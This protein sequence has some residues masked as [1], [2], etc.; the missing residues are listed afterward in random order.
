MPDAR[1]T[2]PVVHSPPLPPLL[3]WAGGKRQLLPRILPLLPA[4]FNRYFEP[5]VGGG[6]LFFHLRPE[7]AVL[8]DCNQ[9]LI[10][11]YREV[12]NNPGRVIRCLTRFS[13]TEKDYYRVRQSSPQTP[14]ERAA[15][16][17]YLTTLSFN[18]LYRQNLRGEFN[19]PYGYKT[20]LVPCDKD[21][22]RVASAALATARLKCNDFGEILKTASVGDLVYLDPPYTV[23]HGNNGFIKYNAKIF[24][25]KDQLRLAHEAER[26]RR[27]G[28]HII[29]T[30]ADHASIRELYSTF[31][32][33][34]LE[35]PSVMAASASY[36]RQII[37]CVFCSDHG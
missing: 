30:N 32:I 37:E 21:R 17:I 14:E 2:E 27:L 3:K 7:Q 4:R 6:A 25:W 33:H 34:E 10:E 15:R 31:A 9:D 12:K 36:R 35:R 29:V 19:V 11:C 5:F 1:T 28:C 23:A 8:G 13:N 16:L 22:I 20:H 18:G 26:L 24:S